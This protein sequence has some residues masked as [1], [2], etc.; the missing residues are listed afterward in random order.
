MHEASGARRKYKMKEV[1]GRLRR[2]S[3]TTA[4]K[5]TTSEKQTALQ[6]E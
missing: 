2:C 1:L 3:I 5:A 4:T 6:F